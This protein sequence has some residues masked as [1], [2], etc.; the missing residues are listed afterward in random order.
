MPDTKNII[1]MRGITKHYGTTVANNEV[2]FNLRP[3]EIHVLL[4]ENGARKTTLMNILF[5]HVQ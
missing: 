2:D 5:G 3:Q 1:S 4:G